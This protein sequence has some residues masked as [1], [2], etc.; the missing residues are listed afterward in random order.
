MCDAAFNRVSS[1]PASVSVCVALCGVPSV[2][3]V[4]ELDVVGSFSFVILCE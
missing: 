2:I 1:C 4:S 3:M